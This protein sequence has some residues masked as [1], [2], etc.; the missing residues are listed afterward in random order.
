L[1]LLQ[2]PRLPGYVAVSAT[3]LQGIYAEN[4]GQR[5]YYRRLLSHEPIAI[6]GHSIYVYYLDRQW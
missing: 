1:K 4:E 3:L 6:I 2:R 5:D